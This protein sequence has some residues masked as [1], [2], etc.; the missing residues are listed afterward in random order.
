LRICFLAAI[1]ETAFSLP[2]R[3]TTTVQSAA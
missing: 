1:L 3:S 2:H